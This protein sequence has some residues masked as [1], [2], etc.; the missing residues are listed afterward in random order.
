MTLEKS[1]VDLLLRAANFAKIPAD[2]LKAQQ[3]WKFTGKTAEMLQMAV[4]TLDP[5][6]AAEWRSEAGGSISLAT[7]AAEMGLQPHTKETRE[8]LLRHDPIA[9]RQQQQADEE[10]F[11]RQLKEMEEKTK[12]LQIK[13]HGRLLDPTEKYYP[14]TWQGEAMRRQDKLNAAM[15]I[16]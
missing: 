11:Q 9:V 5:A 12:E 1:D 2:T 13:N 7:H 6:K 8:D 3:P 14:P 15:G 10:D 16:N 4:E